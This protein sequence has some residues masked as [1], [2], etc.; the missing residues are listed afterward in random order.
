MQYSSR[1]AVLC[2]PGNGF[3]G[4]ASITRKASLDV[5]GWPQMAP[6]HDILLGGAYLS[7]D[8]MLGVCFAM[9]S[10]LEA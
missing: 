3:Q 5:H 8:Y 1:P 2:I 9:D 10:A 6:N 4:C 7:Q